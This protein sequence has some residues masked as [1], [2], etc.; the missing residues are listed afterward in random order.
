MAATTTTMMTNSSNEDSVQQ[1]LN[2]LIATNTTPL[3]AQMTKLN[4]PLPNPTAIP[5]VWEYEKLRPHLIR[6]GTLVAEKQAE[7]R[8]LL[9][10]NPARG[11]YSPRTGAHRTY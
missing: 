8:V 2:D 4:P 11:A 10:T 7:R 9:L 3:W 5:F 1:L 6:A